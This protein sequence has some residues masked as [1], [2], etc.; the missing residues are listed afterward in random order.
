VCI[1]AALFYSV[2][3]E[4]A[5]CNPQRVEV[6]DGFSRKDPLIEQ[7]IRA[8]ARELEDPQTATRLLADCAARF[9]A[10]HLLRHYCAFPIREKL[11]KPALGARKLRQVRD[12]IEAHVSS[13]LNLDDLAS[14]AHISPFHF[15]RLFKT[16]TG[17]TPHDFVT[18]I[19]ME[20]AKALLKSTDWTASKIASAVG[21]SSKSHFAAA[22][23]RFSGVT[24]IR[25][26]NIY[27]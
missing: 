23:Q 22:F 10:I 4:A 18:G 24:P 1:D 17:E 9:L 14:V 19:R 7:V 16:A 21:F 13:A 2:A 27:R 11:T 6:I 3:A 26:R 20:R 25:F 5:D 12:Y 15:A 8:L